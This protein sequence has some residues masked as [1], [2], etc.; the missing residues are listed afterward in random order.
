MRMEQIQMF[1]HSI[2]GLIED[3]KSPHVFFGHKQQDS[4]KEI[5]A[6]TSSG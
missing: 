3:E 4:E 2:I 6:L 5:A 1:K